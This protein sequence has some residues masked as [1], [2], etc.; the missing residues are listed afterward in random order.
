MGGGGVQVAYDRSVTMTY[1]TKITFGEMRESGAHDVVIYCPHLSLRPSDRSQRRRLGRWRPALRHLAK[2]HLHQ[3]RPARCR[4][5]AEV[6][7]DEL[8][9][10]MPWS[11]RVTHP[12]ILDGRELETLRDAATYITALPKAEH[13]WKTSY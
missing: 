13:R 11:A 5:Q 10:L 3:M 1:P 7:P 2:V 8:Q 4:D 9:R 6:A 12:I